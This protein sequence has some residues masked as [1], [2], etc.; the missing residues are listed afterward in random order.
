LRQLP[1][2]IDRRIDEGVSCEGFRRHLEG[3]HRFCTIASGK[4]E[5]LA[6]FTI[7]WQETD[8]VWRMTRVLSYGHR[9]SSEAAVTSKPLGP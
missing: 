3:T 1:A 8:G 4:C 5:G 2:G 7:V 9:A 6:D